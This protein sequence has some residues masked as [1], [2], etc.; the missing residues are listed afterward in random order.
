MKQLC[1]LVFV[2]CL[3]V[4]TSCANSSQSE[5][6][7]IVYDDGESWQPQSQLGVLAENTCVFFCFQK[8]ESDNTLRTLSFGVPLEPGLYNGTYNLNTEEWSEELKNKLFSARYTIDHNGVPGDEWNGVSAS[9]NVISY[10]E[11]SKLISAVLDMTM[12][13]KANGQTKQVKV[14]LEN[15][16]VSN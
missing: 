15:V 14:V 10:D 2:F 4:C 13:C 1:Y 16:P 9:I 6:V 7:R 12:L 11:S 8:E 5:S 3:F